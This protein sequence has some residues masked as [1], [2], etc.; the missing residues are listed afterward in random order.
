MPRLRST[1][2]GSACALGLLCLLLSACRTDGPD[3]TTSD[4]A[5]DD[6]TMADASSDT[7]MA[8]PDS[9]PG[10]EPPPPPAPGTARMRAKI[11][12]CDAAAEPVRCQVRIKEVLGYGSATPPLSAGERTVGV[13]S[14]LLKDRDAATL[15]TLSTRTVV[16]RH[17]GDRPDFGDQPE[18]E[19]PPAWTIQS[20]E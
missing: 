18:D 10:Q 19:K 5:G 12:S 7:S 6:T 17:A 9:M 1:L 4:A 13:A 15:D 3:T 14:S 11:T 20:I 16:L 2:I 8:S